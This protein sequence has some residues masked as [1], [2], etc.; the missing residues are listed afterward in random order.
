MSFLDPQL[1]LRFSRFRKI[2]RGYYSLVIFVT[3]VLLSLVA[4]LLVNSRAVVVNYQDNW[5][6]PTYGDFIPGTEFGLDYRYE[7][8]YRQLKDKIL[9]E[10]LDGFVLLPPVPFNAFENDLKDGAYPPFPP[11]FEDSH[12]L[13]TD[14]TGR[15]VMARLVYGFRIAVLFSLLLLISNFCIGIV[16]G[17]LM[18][19]W[20]GAFDLFFQRLIEIWSNVPFLYVVIIVSSIVVPDLYLL[21]G[22]MVFFGWMPMTWYL[23]TITYRE[24]ARDYVA[25][26][27]TIGA[28]QFRIIGK[29]I[30]PNSVSV[31]ITFAPFAFVGGISSL[32]ALD[33]LGF[34][35]PAPT[36][37]W[38]ELLNQ[39]KENLDAIW[40]S[41]SVILAMVS[42]LLMVTFIGEAV[43]EAFDPKKY[44][45]YE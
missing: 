34:G 2:R 43:R 23:R 10:G 9:E 18:G 37:S 36:P 11:S 16:V 19:Y 12:Y 28:S 35:L 13:G 8:N 20:G 21:V 4:E 33:Y 44:T 3:L 15:D 25:A 5:Y 32:T 42:V 17:S 41:L 31:I 30:L 39:G 6:F 26:A 1:L 7:T 14:T 38:G 45:F 24:K 22:I 27:R 40:I 29:H